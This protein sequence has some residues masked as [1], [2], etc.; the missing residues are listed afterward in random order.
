MAEPGLVSVI[1]PTRNRRVLL[2]RAIR[3]VLYQTYPRF[4]T[5]VVDDGSSRPYAEKVLRSLHDRR[6]RS[7]RLPARQGIVRARK[8]GLARARGRFIAF[9]DDDDTWYPH[10]LESQTRLLSS[11]TAAVV[12]S[13]IDIRFQDSSKFIRSAFLDHLYRRHP[14]KE[15]SFVDYILPTLV[16]PPFL[17]ASVI[18]H[19]ALRQVGGWNTRYYQ[20]N[21]ELDFYHRLYLRRGPGAFLFSGEPV[22]C[23]LIHK[24]RHSSDAMDPKFLRW[25]HD[26]RVCANL[27]NTQKQ[28]LLDR[29]TLMQ[30]S[31][32]RLD[33]DV[34]TIY[35]LFV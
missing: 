12:Y 21:D 31:A 19:D 1:V 22:F 26:K 7:I 30:E 17:G 14:E 29:V 15:T 6:F 9:L 16:C 27:S 28:I 18:R 8:A 4:E 3:S 35:S 33:I 20:E 34:R 23:R 25:H 2:S 32:K 11:T 5:I 10:K 24:R 13:D